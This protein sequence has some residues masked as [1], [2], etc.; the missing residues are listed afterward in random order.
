[1]DLPDVV[2]AC[3]LADWQEAAARRAS[4]EKDVRAELRLLK[5]LRDAGVES[6]KEVLIK[7]R[8]V[9]RTFCRT[10]DNACMQFFVFRLIAQMFSKKD[11]ERENSAYVC[12][13][14]VSCLVGCLEPA[15][16]VFPFAVRAVVGH[17]RRSYVWKDA[18]SFSIYPL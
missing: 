1:M 2:L 8:C 15:H 17:R 9:S 16:C 3:L 4:V 13:R 10:L 11:H 12:K 5:R 7:N 14:Y 6:W 18:T